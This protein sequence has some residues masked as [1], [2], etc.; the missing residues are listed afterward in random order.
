MLFGM[1]ILVLVAG[2]ALYHYVQGFFSAVVSAALVILAAMIAISY[3]E[4]VAE[5]I[6]V[7]TMPTMAHAVS[8]VG[9]FAI[10]YV[11]ARL[12]TDRLIPG[13]VRVHVLVDKIG[14]G[15]FGVVAGIFATG[16]LALAAQLLPL[17]PSIAGYSRYPLR[18]REVFNVMVTG[19]YKRHDLKVYDEL[20]ADSLAPDRASSLFPLPVD[21]M[22]L[23]LASYLSNGG[24]LAGTRPLKSVHPSYLD[25]LF[26]HRLGPARGSDVLVEKAGVVPLTVGEIYT[27]EYVLTRPEDFE[28]KDLRG[29][30]TPAIYR[31]PDTIPIVIRAAMD[32]LTGGS[33]AMNMGSVRLVL[34]GK[35]YFPV[36]S[37]QKDRLLMTR[38]DDI[39]FIEGRRMVDYVFI[40][41][42]ES[43]DK[44]T[45]GNA[46][47][48]PSDAFLVV[49]RGAR[50]P[51]AGRE[52]LQQAPTSGDIG[53]MEKDKTEWR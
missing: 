4:P 23:G 20:D 8:L 40:V 49:K 37:F 48:L 33:N 13:N 1:I 47:L 32:P 16:I 18:E 7:T 30:R 31:D 14:A 50:A 35:N 3:H 38:P 21:K 25:E 42:T 17:G 22:T 24:S 52:V 12:L 51:L 27:G 39:V 11:F 36:G 41:P 44:K 9:L 6:F 2:V 29:D 15:V 34:D 5:S 43:L 19:T 28:R 10:V 46:Y 53:V 45:E 26:A